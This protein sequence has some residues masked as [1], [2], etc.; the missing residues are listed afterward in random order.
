MA[1]LLHGRQ[2]GWQHAARTM[3]HA[4]RSTQTR[5]GALVWL[6]TRLP[7]DLLYQV[8]PPF[9]PEMVEPLHEAMRAKGGW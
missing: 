5:V 8:M 2:L 7:C 1:C 9:D 3:H 4:A 6:P